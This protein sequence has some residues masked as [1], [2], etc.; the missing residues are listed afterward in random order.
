MTISKIGV[1]VVGLGL[2]ASAILPAFAMDMS[3]ST[4]PLPPPPGQMGT[5]TH[6]DGD[7]GNG[8]QGGDHG[9]MMGSMG[10]ST[11]M[12]DDRRNMGMGSSTPRMEGNHMM[13]STS[14]AALACLNGA[15]LTREAALGTAAGAY[16]QSIALAY[17]TRATSLQQAYNQSDVSNIKMSIKTA[18]S[19]FNNTIKSVRSTWKTTQDTAWKTF[20]TASVACK[21]PS[22]LSDNGNQENTAN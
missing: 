1:V 8:M 21:A 18:W 17:G 11:H 16:S 12:G 15:V 13:A 2:A 4:R 7:H 3:T 9:G 6:M 20:R 19:V 10:T 22:G 14:A 5:S